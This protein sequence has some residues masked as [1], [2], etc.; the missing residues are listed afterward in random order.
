MMEPESLQLEQLF[1]RTFFDGW[2]TLLVGGG[3]EPVYLPADLAN[4][5]HRIVYRED[6]FSSALHETAH[7]CIA[8]EARR[9]RVDFGYWYRPDGRDRHQ[10]RAF[11]QVEVRPQALEWLF[12][13]ATGRDFRPSADNLAS[14]DP[15]SRGP[16]PEFL[17][18]LENQARDWCVTGGMPP[19]GRL[20][21]AAL[22]DHYGVEVVFDPDRYRGLVP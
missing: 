4:P 13:V 8:G 12:T 9:R 3:D 5:C 2:N 17:R 14:D 10:Q 11:E 1:A 18:A 21:A 7:W 22:A 19:R 6:Y 16:S 15:E 20:F